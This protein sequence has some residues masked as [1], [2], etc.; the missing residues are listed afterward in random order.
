MAKV[1]EIKTHFVDEESGING[2]VANNI[3]YL[4]L[5]QGDGVT[6]EEFDANGLKYVGFGI[7]PERV[8]VFTDIYDDA[9]KQF[10]NVKSIKK[11]I[12]SIEVVKESSKRVEVSIPVDPIG[13]EVVA[14][15]VIEVSEEVVEESIIPSETVAESVEEP[16]VKVEEPVKQERAVGRRG[17]ARKAKVKAG[18]KK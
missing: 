4:K 9:Q 1:V 14:T 2:Y 5:G 10:T 18:L 8:K 7:T 17:A 3:V 15:E 16:A 11:E 6:R 13:V 12:E